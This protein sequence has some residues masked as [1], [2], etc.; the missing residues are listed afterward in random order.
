MA[1]YNEIDTLD[2]FDPNFGSY[3]EV[4]QL[5]LLFLLEGVEQRLPLDVGRGVSEPEER[6]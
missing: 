4:D 3:I 1:R 5:F 6:R 2:P